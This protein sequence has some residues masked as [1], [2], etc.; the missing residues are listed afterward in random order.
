MK[1][2][3]SLALVSAGLLLAAG[4]SQADS[5][6]VAEAPVIAPSIA[7]EHGKVLKDKINVRARPDSNS[8]V[9][10]GLKKGDTVDIRERKGEWLKIAAPAGTKCY[11]AAKLI[12]DGAATGDAINVRCGPGAN[13]RDIG[14]LAKGEKVTVV[15][16]K[17]EWTQIAPTANC[18]GWVAAELIEIIVPTPAPAPI[19]IS[20]TAPL[21]PP[22]PIQVA[23]PPVE[24]HTQY[25]VK[26]GYLGIVKEPNAPGPYVLMTEDILRRQYVMTYLETSQTDLARFDGKH[27]RVMGNQRWK[28]GDRYPVI[29][30][31][32]CM[33][34]W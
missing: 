29:T 1:K 28:L 4:Q 5:M 19:Q 13:F 27:V 14:K 16:A 32:R 21:P 34:V 9:I 15:E 18:S 33:M 26:D 22:A 3:T 2:F 10:A 11:V 8:E 17:G 25:V 7:G 23:E 20:D 6:K 24:T 31:E 12:K 30:V